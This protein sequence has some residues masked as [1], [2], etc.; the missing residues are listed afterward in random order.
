MSRVR[1][2]PEGVHGKAHYLFRSEE[3][4][5]LLP[6]SGD[7]G[8]GRRDVPSIEGVVREKFA[9]G[10]VQQ[11]LKGGGPTWGKLLERGRGGHNQIFPLSERAKRGRGEKQ[12]HLR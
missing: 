10:D 7:Q 8:G 2:W 11:Q 5:T 3:G 4:A 12:V 6:E 1:Q 9:I